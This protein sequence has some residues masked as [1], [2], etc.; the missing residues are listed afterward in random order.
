MN[1]RDAQLTLL[2]GQLVAARA[3]QASLQQRVNELERLLGIQQQQQIALGSLGPQ[4]ALWQKLIATGGFP[5]RS[6]WADRPRRVRGI[7]CRSGSGSGA[8]ALAPRA[9][10]G[11]TGPRRQHVVG[12]QRRRLAAAVSEP[13]QFT[14]PAAAHEPNAATG[15]VTSGYRSR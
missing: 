2:Q 13:T 12:G 10:P 1:N 14:L 9:Y 3:T 6:K 15:A 8:G 11:P 7:K 4:A 5:D